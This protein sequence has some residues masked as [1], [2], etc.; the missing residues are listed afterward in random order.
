MQTYY[1]AMLKDVTCAKVCYYCLS[2]G[3]IVT[4]RGA[5]RG[6]LDRRAAGEQVP[7]HGGALRGAA[8]ACG[9]LSKMFMIQIR[10]NK[11]T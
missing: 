3:K 2:H 11:D 9:G 10:L 8:G 1:E 5:L 6:L 7:Q 4:Q